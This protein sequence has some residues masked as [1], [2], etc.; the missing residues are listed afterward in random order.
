MRSQPEPRVR[1]EA[2]A[3]PTIRL[4][5]AAAL[6]A[7]AALTVAGCG[8][9][10][11]VEPQGVGQVKVG[12]VASLAQCRDWNAGTDEE[13]L[14]TIEDIRAQINLEDAPVQTT[15]L[16]DE[17]AREVFDNACAEAYSAP[18]RLYRIYARAAAFETL[19][20]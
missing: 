3:S 11:E 19:A 10:D 2:R 8:E 18:F 16:S 6:L 5:L 13:K 7:V 17:R 14:A 15:S 4:R 20:E 9:E 1:A 12:S